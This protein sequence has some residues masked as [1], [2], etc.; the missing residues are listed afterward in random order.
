MASNTP[1]SPKTWCFLLSLIESPTQRIT[2]GLRWE[3]ISGGHLVQ[4]SCSSRATRSRMPRTTSFFENLQEGRL[5]RL[6]GQPVSV[7]HHPHSKE[8]FCDVQRE[9][10]V[11]QFVPL[12]LARGTT[13]K[14]LFVPSLL[15]FIK[16]NI[17]PEPSP[18][19]SLSA[20]HYKR[21]VPSPRPSLWPSLVLQN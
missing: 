17:P 18:V 10:H 20:S 19:P 21:S 1:L 7:F 8:A 12:T 11:F 6:S 15:V 14:C 16:P 13:E 2:E 5:H 3:G 4:S 9:P